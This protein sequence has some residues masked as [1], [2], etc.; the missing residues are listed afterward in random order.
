MP[1]IKSNGPK[2]ALTHGL[3]A[4]DLVLPWKNEEDF[5][6]LCESLREELFPS[7]PTGE[8]AVLD[9]AHGLTTRLPA[10]SRCRGSYRSRAER[11]GRC[12]RISL[13]AH[14]I[15]E[16]GFAIQFVSRQRHASRR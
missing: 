10:T 13:Q 6:G 9:I 15:M 11:L 7:G 16:I 4:R 12:G 3:Y 2:N 14:G 5:I 1:N 8:A